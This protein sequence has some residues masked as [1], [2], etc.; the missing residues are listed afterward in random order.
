MK[1][2]RIM[3]LL[4]MTS[5][6]AIAT[7]AAAQTTPGEDGI[8][9]S[10]DTTEQDKEIIVT[11]TLVRGIA[12]PG[13]SVISV[14]SAA[15]EETG[16]TSVAQVLQTIPQLGS[17]ASLQAPIANSPEVTV[18]RP[19]LRSLPGFNTAG[20]STT[21]V[22]LDGHRMVGMGNGS[23]SPDPDVIPPG[24]IERVEIVPDGGSA[25][26]GS[27]AVA[28][29][30]NFVTIKRFDGVKVDGSYGFAD[31]YY[32]YDAN[33]TAGRDW[34]SGSIFASYNY[35]KSDEILGIDRD[36]IRQFPGSNGFTS[37]N[38][39]PGNIQA[40]AG[41]FGQARGT[42][43]A[44]PG[45][46]ANTANQCDGSDFATVYPASERHSVFA[47]LTQDLS[48]SITF[49]LR[50][51]YTNRQT[52]VHNG[53]FTFS[54]I[55]TPFPIPGV[56]SISSPFSGFGSPNLKDIVQ[57]VTGQF[58]PNDARLGDIE[59]DTWGIT[60]TVTADLDGNFQLRV[61]GSYGESEANFTNNSVN[62][63][64]LRNAIIAGQ[65]N[66]YAPT[67]ASPSVISAITNFQEYNRTRQYYHNVRAIV[68]G[69][70]FTLPGGAAKIAMGLE[71]YGEEFSTQNGQ[72]VPGFQN[73]GF[74]GLSI[75]GTPIVPAI[76]GIPRYDLDRN[77]K[78]AFGE[79][80]V[81]IFGSDNAS[82]G[83]NELTFSAAGR[84][85]DYSDI[86]S[87]FNPRLGLTY[88]PVE[89]ISI[90]GAW[91]QSFNAPSLADNENASGSTVF[92]LSGASAS[93]FAP[94]ASLVQPAG[95]YP[96]YTGGLIV[97]QR[98]N[99]PDIK[100]QE[101]TTWTAGFDIQPPFIPGLN[102]GATYYNIEYSNFIG[103]PPFESPAVLYRDFGNVITI[104]PS[105]ALLN[106][107]IAG[108]DVING[109]NNPP[110]AGTY[111]FFDARKRNLGDF[112]LD[113]ID[114]RLNYQLPTSFGSVFLNSNGTYELNRARSNV[115][116]APFL[117][118]LSANANRFR[119]RTSAGVEVGPVL[120]QITWNH[121]SGY[122]VDPTVGFVPQ[123]S[124]SDFNIFDLY[125][126]FEVP[127]S[128]VAKDLALTLNVENVFDQDPPE[129]RGG[130]QV[131]G[132]SG[133]ANGNTI[134]RFVQFGI[135]KKF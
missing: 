47:G 51:F 60:P 64:A 81:P 39:S 115:P 8:E 83:L 69:D 89:W 20:G 1:Q 57:Q 49:E 82:P 16:A 13:A 2:V 75:S 94:P 85:D 99:A 106:A 132:A 110:A 26:Y 66:P 17:F 98:G 72:A 44:L 35:A 102:L 50:G 43:Y 114:F 105:Q 116:G 90:R 3:S 68:D 33:V 53:P 97:A 96:A 126:R 84:F 54:Q 101:A 38:C 71:Y 11:G 123:D 41:A 48:D 100:P 124:V 131:A 55:I 10:T 5:A 28:G 18:N 61:L 42:V 121:L 133:I 4:A 86:G 118:V 45:N 129:F 92:V 22:L 58:G 34:S 77:V 23:T 56:P 21:L 109:P 19:N 36:Y 95:P 112:K 113:G 119:V 30:I 9:S 76:A 120:G 27:D 80:V 73:S 91:G 37:L 74:S 24:V 46:V 29:V 79:L 108:A 52:Q 40:L 117:D 7:S 63:R 128:G 125:F 14:D 67:T 78:S 93:F 12:P 130:S 70:L 15:I 87:T 65:F 103:L 122:K 107:A 111:A 31:N 25:I 104:A 62:E 88:K 134:G 135:S 59:L 6:L 32:R 127:G